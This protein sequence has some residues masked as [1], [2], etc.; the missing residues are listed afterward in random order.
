MNTKLNAFNRTTHAR[1][2][3]AV[4]R[5]YGTARGIPFQQVFKSVEAAERVATQYNGFVINLI[6]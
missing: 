6:H 1:Y 2:R 4:A 3:P 5:V